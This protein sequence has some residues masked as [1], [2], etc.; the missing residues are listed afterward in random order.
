MSDRENQPQW[1]EFLSTDPFKQSQTEA[2]RLSTWVWR[3]FSGRDSLMFSV[4]VT[5]FGVKQPQRKELREDFHWAAGKWRDGAETQ[6]FNLWRREKKF[7]SF[8]SHQH[9]Q[10]LKATQDHNF[11]LWARQLFITLTHSDSKLWQQD[12]G[13][14]ERTYETLFCQP[15]NTLTVSSDHSLCQRRL[16]DDDVAVNLGSNSWTWQEVEMS[17]LISPQQRFWMFLKIR[18]RHWSFMW[19]VKTWWDVIKMR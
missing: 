15:K 5:L 9:I 1:T 19:R 10:E 7:D 12:W 11:Y 16:H 2:N 3:V 6:V 4:D 17:L 8:C 13:D 14:D 18:A